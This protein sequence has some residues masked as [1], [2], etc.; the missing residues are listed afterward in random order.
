M[1][2]VH[3]LSRFS[4]I[5]SITAAFLCSVVLFAG[6]NKTKEEPAESIEDIQ[7]RDGVPVRILAAQKSSITAFELLGGA[8]EGYH[9]SKINAMIPGRISEIKVKVGDRVKENASLMVIDPLDRTRSYALIQQKL[10]DATKQRE[11]LQALSKEGGVAADVLEKLEIQI[12]EAKEGL[13]VVRRGQF[14][15][16]TFPG[17]V[18]GVYQNV[19]SSVTPGTELLEMASLDKIRISS[20]VSDA[21]IHR[22]RAGQTA[23][24]FVGN[25]TL[26]GRVEKVPLA[27]SA[28]TLSFSVE[29]VFDNPAMVIRPGMYVPVRVVVEQKSA[30]MV[31]PMETVISEGREQYVYI[32]RDGLAHKTAVK[33]GIRSGISFEILQ[34]V[35]EGD[36]VVVSGA[37]LLHDGLKV[38]VVE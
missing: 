23:L 16:S 30:V 13:E 32:V 6:C 25:D 3:R 11:R 19:N 1:H 18:V 31:L 17:V 4:S 27:G 21:L 34:G 24:A 20:T 12:L 36:N 8:A 35:L 14:V 2:G 33:T 28:S 15:L 10:D 22:F 9:Q 26:K 29:T 7:R 5:L 37:G 38:K